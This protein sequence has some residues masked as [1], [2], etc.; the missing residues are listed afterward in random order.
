MSKIRFHGHNSTYATKRPDNDLYKSVLNLLLTDEMFTSLE[1]DKLEEEFSY[2]WKFHIR[3]ELDLH[4]SVVE[5]D[6][7]EITSHNMVK[8]YNTNICEGRI[9]IRSII[10]PKIKNKVDGRLKKNERFDFQVNL[11]VGKYTGDGY[12]S[13]VFENLYITEN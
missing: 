13:F 12:Y 8:L 11:E 6:T 1:Y 9:F 4:I 5:Y 2:E 7:H 3:K 10:V